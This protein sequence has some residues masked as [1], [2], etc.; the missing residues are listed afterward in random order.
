MKDWNLN[1]GAEPEVSDL[2]SAVGAQQDVVRPGSQCQNT[3][4]P[5]A[6]APENK[7]R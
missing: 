7:C 2:D 5:I 1:I 6:D 3:F 4:P